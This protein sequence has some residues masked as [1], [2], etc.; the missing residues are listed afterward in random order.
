MAEASSS[1]R[2]RVKRKRKSNNKPSTLAVLAMQSTLL[3][4]ASA[5]T[6]GATEATPT[7]VNETPELVDLNDGSDS[8]S[9]EDVAR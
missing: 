6:A 8:D 3:L 9:D 5:D 1:R 2:R 4:L 7:D